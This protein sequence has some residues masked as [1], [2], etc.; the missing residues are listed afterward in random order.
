ME[1]LDPVRCYRALCARD[2]RFDGTFFVGVETTGIYCRPVCT[3]RLP[4]RRRCTFHRSAAAAERAGFRACFRCRPE[5]APGL[6][7]LDAVPRLVRAAVR[8]IDEGFLDER[9]VAALAS[10]LGVSARHLRRA[11]EAELGVSPLELAE[12][13]RLARAKQLLADTTLPVTQVALASGYRSIRRFNAAFR[14]RMGTAPS[15]VRRG[16]GRGSLRV[17]LDARLP[18][19]AE[20][21]LAFLAARTILGVEE[22]A[23]GTWRRVVV[24]NG[25]P[26]VIA[27]TPDESGVV[28][29]VPLPLAR[30]LPRIASRVR[31]V[32]DLDAE[33]A[34]IDSVLR[35][36]PLLGPRVRARP[37]LRLP[38]TLDPF[39]S[40]LR[41]VLGQQVSVRAARTL[42]AR[43]AERF[44]ARLEAADGG[45]THALPDAQAIAGASPDELAALG[46]PLGRARALRSVAEVFASGAI[47][48]STPPD[49]AMA[50][51]VRLPGVGP[52][53]AEYVALRGL[54][55]P[56][57]FLPSDLGVKKALGGARPKQALAR[58]E[59]WRPWRGYALAHLWSTL[60]GG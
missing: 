24:E 46:V 35:R 2:R 36:D 58:A 11:L 49:E 55:W 16:G 33:P 10:E 30:A 45:L 27:V 31:G 15:Q 17:R 60:G 12:T 57:A 34:R 42:V 41:A 32:F 1:P 9:S 19:D 6:A 25:A 40:A 52:W 20:A 5:L 53:T 23:D 7:P 13:R 59:A 8:R 37:G 18:F 14:A 56:D 28:L 38:R 47:D 54:H 21:L 4:S 48:A 29:E 51:L 50:A 39:E 3:A 43:A 44:G 22:V 26:G